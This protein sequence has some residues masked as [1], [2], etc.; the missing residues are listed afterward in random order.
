MKTI[1][2]ISNTTFLSL[3]TLLFISCGAPKMN[4]AT[5]FEIKQATIFLNNGSTTKGK[6]DYPINS[7]EGKLKYKIDN[8]K[9]SIKKNEI[10]KITI[11]TSAGNLEYFNLPLFKRNGVKIRKNKQLL[12]LA[13]KGKVSLYYSQ[14]SVYEQIGQ[15][16]TPVYFTEYYCKR[17]NEAAATLIHIENGVMNKNA[18]FKYSAKRY[19]SD[20]AEIAKKIDDKSFTYK[21]ILEVVALYNSK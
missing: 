7:T 14:G 11:E 6:V 10:S 20:D 18:V 9:K 13:V 2:K 19:F 8:N 16:R 17:E 12:A 3:L 5:N 1:N 21:N 15:V 4:T